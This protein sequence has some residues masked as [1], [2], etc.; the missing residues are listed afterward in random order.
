MFENGFIQ[1]CGSSLIKK[2]K[3]NNI[4]AKHYIQ[5]NQNSELCNCNS[6]VGK[7]VFMLRQKI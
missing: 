1:N 3:K 7:V 4:V 6:G 2:K 5:I